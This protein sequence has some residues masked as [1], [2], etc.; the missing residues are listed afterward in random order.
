M[1]ARLTF[2][3]IA[4]FWVT[5]NVLLWRT[6]YGSHGGD[7]P[8]PVALVW[9]KILTA[10]DASSLSVYEGGDRMGYCEFST[11]IGQ[12]MAAV[13]ADKP[14]PENLVKRAGYQVLLAGNVS[15][16]DFTNRLKF[17]GRLDFFKTRQWRE[18][19]LKITSRL[20]VVEIHS[21][22]TNQSFHVKITSEGGVVEHDLAFADLQNP[23]ALIRA[24]VGNF[25]DTLLGAIDL[26]DLTTASTAPA[27]EWTARRTRV[28]IGTEAVPVYRL[29]TSVL[30]R[31]ITVDVSTL[32]EVLRVQL[33]G[34]IT[35]QIDEWTRP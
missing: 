23:N 2:F 8:V 13:D 17:D 27:L 34:S 24:F 1:A 32:G 6:E 4:A 33:P 22:A 29:E 18:L 28:K 19:N 35:A 5:M 26:P 10:P 30:G 16:G 25:A 7:T 21:L 3:A 14:P 12:E 20:A 9:H 15:F 11:S 31:A